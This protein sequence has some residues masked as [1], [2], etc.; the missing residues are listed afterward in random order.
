MQQPLFSG[1]AVALEIERKFLV[2]S[3][4]WHPTGAGTAY[5]QAYIAT[6][7]P[8]VTVRVRIQ[9]SEARLTLKGPSHGAVRSEFEYPIPVAD[10]RE[11]LDTLCE[12]PVRKTR[13]LV[14]HDGNTWEVDVFTGANEGLIV[15]ELELESEDQAFTRPPWLGTEVTGDPRYANSQLAQHPYSRWA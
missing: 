11:L 7:E 13:Y 8:G 1:E 12:E 4:V 6:R 10:A 5:E 14:E 2:D 9:G 15:A 3:S